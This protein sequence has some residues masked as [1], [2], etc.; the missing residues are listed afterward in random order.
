M[1]HKRSLERSTFHS[2][3]GTK[4]CVP[5]ARSLRGIGVTVDVLDRRVQGIV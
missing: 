5:G 1:L 3:V 2:S 4:N